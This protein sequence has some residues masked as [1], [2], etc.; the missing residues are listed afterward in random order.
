MDRHEA[1]HAAIRRGIMGL[2]AASLDLSERQALGG[3]Y[4]ARAN[5]ADTDR[6]ITSAIAR[7]Q[8]RGVRLTQVAIATEAGIS[9][10][11]VRRR[12]PDIQCLSGLSLP[13]CQRWL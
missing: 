8:V 11:T 7:L 9:E 6:R 12:R 13:P 10:R 2:E 5:A 3:K 4:G 1:R